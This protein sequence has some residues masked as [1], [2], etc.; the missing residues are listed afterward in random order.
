MA[1]DD[2]ILSIENRIIDGSDSKTRDQ[3]YFVGTGNAYV[4]KPI[5]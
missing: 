1:I 3:L 2:R 5:Q 4:R